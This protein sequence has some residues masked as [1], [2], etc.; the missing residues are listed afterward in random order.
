M[1]RDFKNMHKWTHDDEI[2]FDLLMLRLGLISTLI[3]GLITLFML[4]TIEPVQ[5]TVVSATYDNL[6]SEEMA[7]YTVLYGHGETY[8]EMDME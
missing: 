7:A 5:A 3:V 1:T 2:S 6:M 4:L 8:T